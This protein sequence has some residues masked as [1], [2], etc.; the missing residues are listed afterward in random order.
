MQTP[1]GPHICVSRRLPSE[2]REGQEKG[3]RKTESKRSTPPRGPFYSGRFS[4]RVD[5]RI[6]PLVNEPIVKTFPIGFFNQSTRRV[7]D[8][9]PRPSRSP[10]RRKGARSA[11]SSRAPS[12]SFVSA[13]RKIRGFAATIPA[14]QRFH[15]HARVL[16]RALK[17][18]GGGRGE[19]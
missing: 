2:K 10:L 11:D 8:P 6:Q 19:F 3:G 17:T 12:A 5:A 16:E 4:E 13:P 1:R 18:R 9:L 7:R 14:I 15:R